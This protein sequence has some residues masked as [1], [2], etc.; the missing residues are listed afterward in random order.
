MQVSYVIYIIF[1]ALPIPTGSILGVGVGIS[2][3][4]LMFWTNEH[5]KRYVNI[6]P[7]SQVIW[8]VL[9]YSK[10]FMEQ[11]SGMWKQYLWRMNWTEGKVQL[12]SYCNTA[13]ANPMLS[14]KADIAFKVFHIGSEGPSFVPPPL[15]PKYQSWILLAAPGERHD[16]TWVNKLPPSED[17]SCK[18]I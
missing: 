2:I 18:R 6:I 8:N 7:L 5:Y 15:T 13:F 10:I 1:W 16:L 4:I 11:V 3:L 14:F 17:N 12:W 9:W